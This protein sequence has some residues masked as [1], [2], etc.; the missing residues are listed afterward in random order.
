M[1]IQ[2]QQPPPILVS[3]KLNVVGE[4]HA[5][6]DP[7]RR[8]ERLFCLDQTQNNNYWTEAE[9]LDLHE[10]VG[11]RGNR[12]GP[13]QPPQRNASAD[14]MEYRAVHGVAMLIKK[15]DELADAAGNAAASG[16]R[17]AV[18]AFVQV[19]L[20]SFR[21][22]Q[23]RVVNTWT[24]TASGD[25]NTAVQNVYDNINALL[26]K[27]V[28]VMR[29]A[30][31]KNSV[32]IQLKATQVLANG[33]TAIDALLDPLLQAVGVPKASNAGELAGEMRKQRSLAMGLATYTTRIGVWKI[34]DGH[35]QDLLDGTAKVDMSRANFVTRDE[36]NTA[37]DAWK[38]W[39]YQQ[40]QQQ[41]QR[42]LQQ[43]Q[44]SGQPPT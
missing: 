39:K 27:Y 7:R 32:D 40:L 2:P 28:Q 38:R 42:I 4:D 22:D 12:S 26:A 33:R 10:Q 36:F 37:F 21:K 18:F 19:N 9:F 31:A 24:P 8:L 34:G 30:L 11:I 6:S 20:R 29:L 1:S 25:V 17:T 14:L 3:G 16:D 15:F 35:I 44:G 13:V 41:K 23:K 43:Q 5:E